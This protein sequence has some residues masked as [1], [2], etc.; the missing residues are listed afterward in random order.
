M[1]VLGPTKKKKKVCYCIQNWNLMHILKYVALPRN[2]C[3]TDA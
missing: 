2:V 1:L 3:G